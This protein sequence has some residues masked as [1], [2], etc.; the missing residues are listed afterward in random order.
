MAACQFYKIAGA[1]FY[2]V[3]SVTNATTV[4][5]T[6]VGHPQNAA[7]ATVINSGAVIFQAQA[8]A[9]GGTSGANGKNAFTTTSSIF[10]TPV[11]NASVT[12]A[13]LDTSWVGGSGQVLFIAG[14]GYY[15]V[16]TVVDATHI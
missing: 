10:T 13:V 9:A 3:S 6:N 12:I 14:A 7:A 16:S 1:G 4:V 8:V 15:S 11:V 2:S 5:L